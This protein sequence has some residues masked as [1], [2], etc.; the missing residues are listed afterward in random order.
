MLIIPPVSHKDNIREVLL[1]DTGNYVID[2]GAHV[3]TRTFGGPFAVAGEVE[4]DDVSLAPLLNE[5]D[6]AVPQ[7]SPAQ[8]AVDKEIVLQFSS[9]Q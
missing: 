5:R 7:P 8:C 1:F 6:N 4:S 2:V 9:P 3:H